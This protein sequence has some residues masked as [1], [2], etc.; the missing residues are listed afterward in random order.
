V[1]LLFFVVV[2]VL[3]DA[4]EVRKQMYFVK[5]VSYNEFISMPVPMILDC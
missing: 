2:V 5:S 3:C 4:A 1:L